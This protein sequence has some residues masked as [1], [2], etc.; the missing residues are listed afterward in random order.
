MDWGVGY[1]KYCGISIIRV[2]IKKVKMLSEYK[3]SL[4]WENNLRKALMCLE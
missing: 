1:E 4:Y 3:S 2:V